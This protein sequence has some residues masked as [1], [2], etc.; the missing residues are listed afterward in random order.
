MATIFGNPEGTNIDALES[1]SGF[2]IKK[3]APFGL[4]V[5]SGVGSLLKGVFSGNRTPDY[6][7][8]MMGPGP[9]MGGY[10]S[11]LSRLADTPLPALGPTRPQREEYHRALW[12]KQN[13]EQE[14]SWGETAGG[15]LTGGV[16]GGLMGAATGNPLLGVAGGVAGALPS[17]V[18]KIF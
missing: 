4:A 2:D 7:P 16:Q 12:E 3:Y 14:P 1:G 15:M 8:P 13:E 17:L 5:A 18:N 9:I 10:T 6:I 11:F